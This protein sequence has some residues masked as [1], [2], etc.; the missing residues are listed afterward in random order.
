MRAQQM[1]PD[2]T[3]IGFGRGLTA[4]N[5]EDEKAIKRLFTPEFRNRLDATV[6]F[7]P[8]D[9]ASISKVVDKFII[10]LE[11][12]LSD[13]KILFELSKTATQ[14]LADKG[15][16]KRYGARPLSRTIQEHIKKPLADEILFGKLKKGGLV[17][18]SVDRKKDELKFTIL[19]PE[20]LKIE[21]KKRGKGLPAPKPK[22]DA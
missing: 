9:K 10:Q 4:V 12:Q 13:R 18:I 21:G 7:D 1:Q 5:D 2:K 3:E 14:W 11:T 20:Q 19:K 17:K 22:E 8:L 6:K 16:D 15:Y